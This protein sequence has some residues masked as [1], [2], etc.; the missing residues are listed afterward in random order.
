MEVRDAKEEANPVPSPWGLS[1][2]LG[3][4]ESILPTPG[5][6]VTDACPPGVTS[7]EGHK[8][9]EPAETQLLPLPPPLPTPSCL[10]PGPLLQLSPSPPQ[11]LCLLG[12]LSVPGSEGPCDEVLAPLFL[13]GDIGRASTPSE[14]QFPPVQ[15]GVILTETKSP[16]EALGKLLPSSCSSFSL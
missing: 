16:R 11:R 5:H 15:S 1:V 13:S 2:S 8:E 10:A 9:H 4:E 14:P 12:V 7:S 3:E 6:H